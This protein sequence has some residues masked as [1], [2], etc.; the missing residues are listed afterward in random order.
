[1]MFIY[2]CGF[3]YALFSS[4]FLLFLSLPILLNLPKHFYEMYS[5]ID[6]IFKLVCSENQKSFLPLNKCHFY[7]FFSLHRNLEEKR[8][9]WKL[10]DISE[11]SENG[12]QGCIRAKFDTSNGP[13]NPL[14]TALQFIAEGATLSG[15]D[16]ELVGFGYRLSLVKK[17]FGTGK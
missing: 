17:R 7:F 15:L 13:N 12:C 8:A 5:K 3:C 2:N 9:T 11:L 10:S 1:M 6:V 14:P 16:F 4:V